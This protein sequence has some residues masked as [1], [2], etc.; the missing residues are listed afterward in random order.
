MAVIDQLFALGPVRKAIW[1]FWY[2]FFTPRLQQDEGLFLNYADEEE[3]PM[4]IPLRP[5]DEPHRP[6]IQLYHHVATQVPLSGKSVLEVSCGHGGGAA[7]IT[8]TLRPQKYT[9]LDLNP[10]GI[11]FCQRRHQLPGIV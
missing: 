6:H 7:Y 8:R 2:P 11:R 10:E 3:P 1:R 4:R 5:D 9:G